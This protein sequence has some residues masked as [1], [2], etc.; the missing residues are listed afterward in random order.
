[1]ST[2]SSTTAKAPLARQQ[3]HARLWAAPRVGPTGLARGAFAPSRRLCVKLAASASGGSQGSKPT[4]SS[5]SVSALGICVQI[6]GRVVL[7]E[8]W[9]LA[10]IRVFIL[11]AWCPI[12]MPL[13]IFGFL[14]KAFWVWVAVH[15]FFVGA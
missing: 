7:E 4:G 11:A 2:A 5:I 15:L 3:H 6:R 14:G 12:Y 13:S 9:A 8:Y 1:M 10:L